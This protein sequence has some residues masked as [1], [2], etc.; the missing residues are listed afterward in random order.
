MTAKRAILAAA[1]L[2]ILAALVL[3]PGTDAGRRARRTVRRARRKAR[4]VG[5]RLRGV[6]HRTCR[7]DRPVDDQLLAD[8]VRSA[9]G[10]VTRDLDVPHVHVMVDHGVV[11]LHGAVAADPDRDIIEQRASEVA[12]VCGVESYLH[13]GLL[14][15]DTRPSAGRAV[16]PPSR[17][18]RRLERAAER[19][20][21]IREGEAT[22]A[23]RAVLAT[24]LE[25]IPEGERHQVLTHLP[26]DVRALT[27]MPRRL[28]SAGTRLRTVDELVATVSDVDPALGA[29]RARL[30]T[31]AVLG[32]LSELIPEEREDVAAI[33]PADL[34]RLWQRGRDPAPHT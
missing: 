3:R 23:V 30:V 25:R 32:E 12:G 34:R 20:G 27:R 1:A 11:L 8:R 26:A 28:G 10:T 13:L 19:G 6:V 17:A 15:N 22:R 5:N 31:D 18:R 7:R 9:L 29:T 21:A 2:A 4:H 33:L 14:R 24:F 16:H